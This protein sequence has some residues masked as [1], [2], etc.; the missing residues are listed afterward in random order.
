MTITMWVAG[1]SYEISAD[2][3]IPWICGV[4]GTLD[5]FDIGYH[6]ITT[7][8]DY[9]PISIDVDP[10][11][12]QGMLY[13]IEFDG[14]RRDLAESWVLP[15]V[16]GLAVRNGVEDHEVFDPD[17]ANRAQLVQALM[18]GHQRRWFIY[19]GFTHRKGATS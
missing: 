11:A 12:D 14:A 1:R 4:H 5:T 6:P 7:D 19:D 17:A 2:Q 15:W 8:I 16:R 3:V 18:V 9:Y 10:S 13:H